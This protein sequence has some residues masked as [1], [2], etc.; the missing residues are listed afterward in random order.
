LRIAHDRRVPLSMLGTS[1]PAVYEGMGWACSDWQ[2]LIEVQLDRLKKL[3]GLGRA[4]RY[5][6]IAN[7]QFELAAAL[8][9]R[10]LAGGTL[11]IRRSDARWQRLDSVLGPNFVGQLLVHCDGYMI[12]DLG[13]SKQQDKLVIAEW[14]YLTDEAFKDGLAV[15]ANMQ[16]QHNR[17]EWLDSTPERLLQLGFVSSADHMRIGSG[18]MSR[19][20]HLEAFEEAIDASLNHVPMRDPLAVTCPSNN[21]GLTPGQLVQLVTGFWIEPPRDWPKLDI[22]RVPRAFTTER[23]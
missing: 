13:K 5:A 15:F 17:V 12:L 4:E 23:F 6:M 20:V 9:E 22:R 18:E 3:K 8:R 21:D 10:W 19:V 1:K 2:Y 14:V 11:G 16:Y 7:G